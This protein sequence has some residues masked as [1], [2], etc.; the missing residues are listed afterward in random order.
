MRALIP[1]AVSTG[2]EVGRLVIAT[3][4]VASQRAADA[5]EPDC[6]GVC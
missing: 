3:E 6:Y 4:N 1:T 5:A 2:Y